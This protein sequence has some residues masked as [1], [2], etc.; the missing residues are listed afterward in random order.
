[1]SKADYV[2]KTQLNFTKLSIQ[3]FR[4]QEDHWTW[5][6]VRKFLICVSFWVTKVHG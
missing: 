5:S 1:M 6:H 3:P 4:E 2:K